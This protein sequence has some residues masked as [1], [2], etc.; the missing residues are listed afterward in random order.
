MKIV[1]DRSLLALLVC[2]VAL[3]T[4]ACGDDDPLGP[5]DVN[6]APELG[7]DLSQMRRLPTGV[8]VQT[9]MVGL[10]S[11]AVQASDSVEIAYTLWLPDATVIDSGELSLYITS[12]IPGVRD[13]VV[14]MVEQEV[15]LIVVPPERGYGPNPPRGSGIPPNAVL[16]F[17]VELLGVPS[18][19]EGERP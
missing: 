18:K 7:V 11:Y 17:R 8:Y 16:V 10:G 2:A 13:G 9:L 12:L 1:R 4:G 5:E 6:Y 14:D 3:S 19:S 15:R